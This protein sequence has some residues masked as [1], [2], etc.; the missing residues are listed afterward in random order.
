[1]QIAKILAR[2]AAL[3]LALWQKLPARKFDA[4]ERPEGFDIS[5]RASLFHFNV[6]LLM[7]S[8]NSF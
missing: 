7:T 4:V 5:V 2:E 8:G 3:F 6:C 1:M